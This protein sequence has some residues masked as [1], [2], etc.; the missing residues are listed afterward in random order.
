METENEP[1][2]VRP[3]LLVVLVVVILAGISFFTWNYLQGKKTDTNIA[4]VNSTIATPTPDTAIVV[5]SA[6]P[7]VSPSPISTADW[8]TYTDATYGFSFK[9]PASLNSRA[10]YSNL[11]ANFGGVAEDIS[12]P[13][14]LVYVYPQNLNDFK[15]QEE[16]A[17]TN[18]PL[19][20]Q[21]I[22][23]GGHQAFKTTKM[24]GHETVILVDDSAETL[25]ITDKGS[26]AQGLDDILS[27]FQFIK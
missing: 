18:P 11:I 17:Y 3:W 24:N 8:K 4:S 6:T 1:G 22:T 25:L 21:P 27:T 20:F 10:T 5:P 9:Y 2:M 14:L 15:K 16:S 12:S 19:D 26:F 23:V 13:Q 7:T